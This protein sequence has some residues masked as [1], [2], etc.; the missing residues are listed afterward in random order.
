VHIHKSDTLGENVQRVHSFLREAFRFAL[1]SF[2][3]S[4]PSDLNLR[5]ASH[6]SFLRSPKDAHTHPS[7]AA[8]CFW[9][10]PSVR[11]FLTLLSARGCGGVCCWIP[12]SLALSP[13]HSACGRFIHPHPTHTPIFSRFCIHL[14]APSSGEGR[15]EREPTQTSNSFAPTVKLNNAYVCFYIAANVTRRRFYLLSIAY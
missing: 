1:R 10:A 9:L 5:N 2:F 6:P 12:L 15:R 13:T 3:A 11:P 7:L 4:A 14:L 8:G